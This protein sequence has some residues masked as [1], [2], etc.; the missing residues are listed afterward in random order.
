MIKTKYGNAS[1]RK[2]GNVIEVIYTE[3][4]VEI[5]KGIASGINWVEPKQLDPA[6]FVPV[7]YKVDLNSVKKDV[8]IKD[9]FVNSS[10]YAQITHVFQY[11]VKG[12]I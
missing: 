3:D 1:Y 2:L 7:T 6:E 5:P 11:K 4:Y 8:E 9:F 10:H 12:I